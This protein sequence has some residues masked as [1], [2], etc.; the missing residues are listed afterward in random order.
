MKVEDVPQD[1]KF[2]EGTPVRHPVYAVDSEGKYQMVNSVGW[3]AKNEAIQFEL[4]VIQ[5]ECDEILER[6]KKGETSL[7]EYY[8]VKNLM[9]VVLLA[10]YSGVP[11]R[12]VRKHM[13][14]PEAFA[15]LDEKT[16]G[17]YAEALRM[18]VEELKT[19]PE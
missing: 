1:L 12:K 10:H 11:K 19:I 7:L 3:E 4:D 13:S 6:V 17:A 15:S 9:T 8:A 5:E 18:T 16:L 14:D 2:T